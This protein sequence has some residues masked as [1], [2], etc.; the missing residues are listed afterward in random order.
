MAIYIKLF[1]VDW[2]AALE[3]RDAIR[4]EMSYDPSSGLIVTKT[5]MGEILLIKL[6][7]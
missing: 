6:S 3:R 4:Y 5:I 2:A 7:L 1:G